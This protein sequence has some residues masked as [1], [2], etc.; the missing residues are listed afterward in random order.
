MKSTIKVILLAITIN[1][2]VW[3]LVIPPFEYPDEQAHFA[4]VQDIAEIGHVPTQG[5][6]TS[7]EV[8]QSEIFLRTERDNQG[9]NYFTYHPERK[10]TYTGTV[11]GFGEQSIK[12]LP[13]TARSTLI[14]KESTL[15]PPVYY[16]LASLFYKAAF[17]VDLFTRIFIVRLLSL[18]FLILTAYF[19]FKTG[20]LI[21]KSEVLPLVLMVMVGFMP[22]FV[23]ASTGILPDSFTNFL[24]TVVIY[25]N[26][27]LLKKGISVKKLLIL[28]S[29]IALGVYS[30]QQFLMAIPFTLVPILVRTKNNLRHM[31]IFIIS[32]SFLILFILIAT[33]FFGSVPVIG[34]FTLP[35]AHILYRAR[36]LLS[37]HLL[38]FVKGFILESYRQTFPWFWGVY[39]WLSL[40]MPM[41]YYQ[42]IK[43]ILILSFIGL[44]L[45][46]RRAF[47]TKKISQELISIMFMI[48]V[49]TVY[50]LFFIV[51]GYLFTKTNNYS[52][53][54]QGRYFFPIIVPIMAIIV[55]GMESILE[56]IFK[57]FASTSLVIFTLTILVLNGFSLFVVAHSYYVTTN[58]NIFTNHISSYKPELIKGPIIPMIIFLSFALQ[59]YMLIKLTNK[60]QLSTRKQ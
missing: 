59:G 4:Q 43:G 5:R 2:F 32:F 10:I 15:N 58:L 41:Y 38:Y 9:N 13:G 33:F 45:S 3:Q 22:M 55:Y 18:V 53:G 52:F 20:K 25:L 35:D 19:T 27:N 14:K 51:W 26:L 37:V 57:R 24:M 11:E 21:F 17:N 31:A 40:T 29:V 34:A 50:F 54:F 8:Q 39:K 47:T 49:T 23:Y 30:R 36:S 16:Q 60:L 44:C 48:Y 12:N 1:G 28:V 7:L 6:D 46:V 42:L 56:T